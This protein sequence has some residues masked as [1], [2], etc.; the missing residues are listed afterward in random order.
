M[1]SVGE[2]LQSKEFRKNFESFSRADFDAISSQ[3]FLKFPLLIVNLIF[4]DTAITK[5][6]IKILIFIMRFSF[7]CK[8]AV[9]HLKL[10]DFQKIGFYSSD[11][12]K[13]LERLVKKNYIGWDKEAETMWINRE[14][15][16][17]DESYAS[18]ILRRN[19]VNHFRKRKYSTS[20]NLNKTPDTTTKSNTDRYGKINIDSSYK[21]LNSV[22]GNDD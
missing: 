16:A 18:D 12:S 13:E 15:L 10:T 1:Q 20:K 11:I 17:K 5:R 21:Y 14:T 7:G 19:L 9:A 4:F 3:R 8:Q 2:I 6:Q 22:V